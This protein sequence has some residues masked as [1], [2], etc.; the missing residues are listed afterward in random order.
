MLLGVTGGCRAV[1]A[2]A[3]TMIG[4]GKIL[5]EVK[6]CAALPSFQVDF[7]SAASC[8]SCMLVY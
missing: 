6:D 3:D 8:N 4:L 7:L 5:E 2:N 1:H